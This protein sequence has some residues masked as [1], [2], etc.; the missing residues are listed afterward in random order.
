[1]TVWM[2]VSQ[3]EFELPVAV[4]GTARELA[5][6]RNTTPMNIITSISKHRRGVIKRCKYVKVTVDDNED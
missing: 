3:D 2:E 6:L 5:K 4:A 1:M